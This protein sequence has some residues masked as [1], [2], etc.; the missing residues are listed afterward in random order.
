VDRLLGYVRD[1]Q[2]RNLTVTPSP[3]AQKKIDDFEAT[4]LKGLLDTGAWRALLSDD[5]VRRLERELGIQAGPGGGGRGRLAPGTVP[6][7]SIPGNQAP[8]LGRT[9][10]VEQAAAL[11][12]ADYARRRADLFENP[13]L[14]AS[15]RGKNLLFLLQDYGK[16]LDK[17]GFDTEP[18]KARRELLQAFFEKPAAKQFGSKDPDDDLLNTAW[19]IVWGTD[20]MDPQSSF[21]VD[22]HK[23]WTAYLSMDGEFL[24]T[25]KKIDELLAA[26]GKPAKVHAHEKRSPVNWLVGEQTGNVKPTS[27][28]A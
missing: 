7:G 1:N 6:Q 19:E 25:A 5:G 22:Q 2:V 14:S 15:Q 9:A 3:P 17:L 18:V 10:R 11:F 12:N 27:T 26:Q 24:D 4:A 21:T 20:P 28:F 23:S 8:Q 13:Q 16:A